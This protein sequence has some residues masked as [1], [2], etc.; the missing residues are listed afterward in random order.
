MGIDSLFHDDIPMISDSGG[1]QSV[2]PT[3]CY[4][5]IGSSTSEVLAPL[6]IDATTTAQQV[7]HLKQFGECCRIFY[8][9]SLFVPLPDD[10]LDDKVCVESIDSNAASVVLEALEYE[11][12]HASDVI[13]GSQ[14][15][16]ATGERQAFVSSNRAQNHLSLIQ[17]CGLLLLTGSRM[18]VI[19]TALLNISWNTSKSGIK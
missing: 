19:V 18:V 6:V 5:S 12:R 13:M 9:R 7:Q 16:L 8:Q 4:I 2:L 10:T 17:S 15:H 11:L 1:S 14:C 3:A